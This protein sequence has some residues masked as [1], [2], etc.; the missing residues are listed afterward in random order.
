VLREVPKE[1]ES[2]TAATYTGY[3]RDLYWVL[4]EPQHSLLLR[5][6]RTPSRMIGPHGLL[7]WPSS[8]F[9][10][11]TLLSVAGWLK[12]DLTFAPLRS[13]PPFRWLVHAA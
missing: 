8:S 12:I 6:G 1:I 9:R 13:Q 3:Y 2:T 5:L 4:M 11:R 10:P 7:C